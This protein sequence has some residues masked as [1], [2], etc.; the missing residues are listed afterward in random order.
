MIP[1]LRAARDMISI[2]T[3]LDLIPPWRPHPPHLSTFLSLHLQHIQPPLT[4]LRYARTDPVHSPSGA[5]F[6]I[7]VHA[8]L[9]IYNIREPKGKRGMGH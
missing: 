1:P 3:P 4:T 9:Y 5:L 2:D 8:I 6:L 7:F